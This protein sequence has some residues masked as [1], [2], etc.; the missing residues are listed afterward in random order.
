MR[1]LAQADFVRADHVLHLVGVQQNHDLVA[2]LSWPKRP[3]EQRGEAIET[4]AAS[5]FGLN[6]LY[7]A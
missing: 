2:Y 5:S 4:I 7:P 6:S 1:K 3:V